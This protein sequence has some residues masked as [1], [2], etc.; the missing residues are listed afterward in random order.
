M[1]YPEFLAEVQRRTGLNSDRADVTISAFMGVLAERL[2]A[3]QVRNLAVQLPA[4]LQGYLSTGEP[5]QRKMNPYEFYERIA[6]VEGI[7]HTLAREHARAVWGAMSLN[8]KAGELRDMLSHL[9]AGLAT[10]LM[11]AT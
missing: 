3:D 9:P 7:D 4:E 2:P 10:D 6:G 11:H 1:K 5:E 8:V